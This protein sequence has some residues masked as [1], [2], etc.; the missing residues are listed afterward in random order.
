MNT[1]QIFLSTEPKETRQ[2]L[3]WQIVDAMESVREWYEDTDYTFYDNEA[4][5]KFLDTHFAPEIR[6]AYDSLNPL[7]YKADLARYCILYKKGGW[8]LDVGL[9]AIG[10]QDRNADLY[11]FRS[12]NRYSG[13]SW[14]C[15]NG[16]FYAEAG[17][18]ALEIAIEMVVESVSN[19]YYGK[20]P[21]CPTGPSLWGRAI[22]ASV[23]EG[24]ERTIF[25]DCDEL[26]PFGAVKNKCFI[27]PNGQLL[28]ECKPAAGGDLTQ[29]GALDTNNYNILWHHR[30]VYS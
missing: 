15:D 1:T 12:M 22:A 25:G 7:A 11:A 3:P 14:A 29:M 24:N 30:K 18:P 16:M 8:Y 28:S 5:E 4:V 23:R 26:T 9:T 6:A 19:K 2:E 27:A 21:L 10:R 20:T 13:T 17:N